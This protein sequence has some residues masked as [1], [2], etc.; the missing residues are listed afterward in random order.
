VKAALARRLR[1]HVAQGGLIAYATASCYGMGCDPMNPRAIAR[2]LRLKRRPKQK[3]LI[4]IADEFERLVPFVQPLDREARNRLTVKWP[5]PHTWLVA[6]SRRTTHW[7]RGAHSK[8]AVRIDAHPDAR[9]V[10]RLLGIAVVS[11]SLNRAGRKAIRGFRE[12]RRQF[13][14]SVL[15]LPGKIGAAQAPSTIQDFDTG[16]MLR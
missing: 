1:S 9:E 10:C 13:G 5:G 6:A 2:L 14:A 11:T 3:G 15:V 8:V 16:R 4:L 7:V 12:A